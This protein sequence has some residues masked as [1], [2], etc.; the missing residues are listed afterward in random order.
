[1][2]ELGIPTT[3]ALA[4]VTTGEAVYRERALPGAILTRVAESHIRVGTFEFFYA[5][6][7]VEA[8]KALADYV[9]RRHYPHLADAANPYRA[10]LEAVVARQAELVARWMLVGFIHGV[11]NTDNCSIAGETIDYGPCALMDQYHPA[12]VFSSIDQR[13]RYAYA[14]QPGI[15]A[16]NLAR[17]ATALLPLLGDDDTA[18]AEGQAA[19]DTFPQRYDAAWREGMARKLGLDAMGDDDVELA[20]DLLAAMAENGA[21]FTLTFRDLCTLAAPDAGADAA[22]QVRSLFADPAAF[23]A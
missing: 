22:G 14:N 2:A 5:R 17:L 10:L 11:M 12:T 4:A 1:M 8:L 16:W 3:R 6:R 23:D 7:D 19:I 21:D 9:I 15:A 20:Q 18:V 13:G